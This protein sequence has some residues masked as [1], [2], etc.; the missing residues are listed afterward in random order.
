M[1][2]I[3]EGI[4]CDHFTLDLPFLRLNR[5]IINSANAISRILYQLVLLIALARLAAKSRLD[6]FSFAE[7]IT[8]EKTTAIEWR[9]D[10]MMTQTVETI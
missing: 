5:T 10:L 9:N 1:S 4:F 7:I 6:K 3:R 2:F 8:G